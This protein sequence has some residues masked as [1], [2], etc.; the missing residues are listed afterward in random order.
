MARL[1]C[2]QDPVTGTIDMEPPLPP[3]EL[4][5][6]IDEPDISEPD[7]DEPDISEPDMPEPDAT[8][9]SAA[10]VELELE[11]DESDDE[12][13]EAALFTVAPPHPAANSRVVA[14]RPAPTRVGTADLRCDMASPR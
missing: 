9:D 3:G 10:L 2:P 13:G 11:V 12:D 5:P 4:D 7:I 6:D 8:G 1:T 14:A